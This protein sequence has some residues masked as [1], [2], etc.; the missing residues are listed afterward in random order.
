M[1]VTALGI[2]RAGAAPVAEAGK[3]ADRVA[4]V[5][6]RQRR[7]GRAVR[8]IPPLPVKAERRTHNVTLRAALSIGSPVL[9]EGLSW[10]V[11]KLGRNAEE[12]ELVWSGGGAEPEIYLKPGR[13]FAEARY[14]L[15]SKG[16][17]F[18]VAADKPVYRTLSLDAGTLIVH[19]SAVPGAAP[20]EDVFFVLRR[21]GEGANAREEIGRSSIPQAVFHVPAGS[22]KVIA[23]HGLA[24]V[25]MPVELAAGAER[26]IEVPMQTGSLKLTARARADTPPMSG[27]TYFVFQP[28]EAGA[29][30]REIARSKLDEPLFVLTSGH[31]RIAAVLGLARVEKDIDIKAGETLTHDLVLEAG[32]VRLGASLAGNG[33]PIEEHLLYR[34]FGSNGGGAPSEE[35]L[36]STTASPTLFLPSGRYRIESQYGWHNARQVRDVEIKS[37]EVEDIAFEHKASDVK[38]RLVDRP[39]GQSMDRVKWTLKYNGGGTVL[40]SQDAAPSLILQAGSYQ[41][42]AQHESKTY[43]QTFEAASNQEQ[44]VEIVAQ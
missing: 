22:Y 28:G 9:G 37:G 42:M 43:T 18:E 21:T 8:A 3:R 27:V 13:Y 4:T 41:A 33:Q 12:R 1:D 31:Y 20:L 16:E 35:L 25:E 30:S 15:A 7:L 11:F 10:R 6:Y 14:G 40:I 19:A 17:T 32:G 29:P 5:A 38:L 26:R 2:G 39:G 44:I 23:K 34:V 36:T 24:S